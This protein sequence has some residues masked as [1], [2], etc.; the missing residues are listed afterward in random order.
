[1]DPRN[2]DSDT[3]SLCG[4]RPGCSVE[5][6]G[7]CWNRRRESEGDRGAA[8]VADISS[9]RLDSAIY[10]HV[11]EHVDGYN[12]KMV[13]LTALAFSPFNLSN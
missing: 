1:M 11:V 13:L 3:I 4:R 9:A 2:G 12:D 5:G 7:V 10:G 8:D 6:P